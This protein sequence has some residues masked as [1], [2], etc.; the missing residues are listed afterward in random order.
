MNTL[1]EIKARHEL[2][3]A[4]HEVLPFTG[5][6]NPELYIEACQD[7]AVLI[8]MVEELQA[9]LKQVEALR[10]FLMPCAICQEAIDMIEQSLKG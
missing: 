4:E 3:Q 2:H 6:V 1:K 8:A 5:W 10:P 7:R 9:K